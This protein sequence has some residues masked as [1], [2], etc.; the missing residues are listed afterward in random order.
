MG[1]V[2]SGKHNRGSAA[3][4]V[5]VGA[6]DSGGDI[7]GQMIPNQRNAGPFV[8]DNVR[9]EIANEIFIPF[10]PALLVKVGTGCGCSRHGTLANVAFCSAKAAGG[11]SRL[12]SLRLERNHLLYRLLPS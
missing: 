7:A 6:P 12:N 3:K 2:R 9:L 8:T 10:Q 1:G 4:T 5:V 11:R